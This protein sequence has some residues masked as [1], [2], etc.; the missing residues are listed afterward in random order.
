MEFDVRQLELLEALGD[1]ESLTA[2]AKR[3]FVTQPALSQRLAAL[4]R[5]ARTALFERNGR[6]L[7][8]TPAG[9][10]MIGAARVVLGELRSAAED[11][12]R[13]RTGERRP[14]RITSQ[15]ST[16]YQWLP[17]LLR[18]FEERRHGAGVHVDN[19]A[20]DAPIAALLADRVD[21]AI[22]TK[23]DA[24]LER[25]ELVPLFDDELVAVFAAAHRFAAREHLTA[26]DFDDTHVVL[27]DSYA[28]ARVPHVPLPLPDGARP[29]R[30]STMPQ[31]TELIVQLVVASDAVAV[32]P[33][34]VVE[35][36]RRSHA[37]ATARLTKRGMPRTW[38]RATRRGDSSEDLDV[39]LTLLDERFAVRTRKKRS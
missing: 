24:A 37:I 3:L 28:P 22:V 4:E 2:A 31:L 26:R 14:V 16:N 38:F 36:Y 5:A 19:A 25:L 21:V 17:E 32:L 27:Y 1:G 34:W 12:R 20:G 13:L 9:R 8:P 30:L 33:S 7:V 18:A 15:C 10:R 35:P 39:F 6:T 11:V 29:R 23:L